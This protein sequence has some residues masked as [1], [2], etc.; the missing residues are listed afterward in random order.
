M[1]TSICDLNQGGILMTVKPVMRE[2][3]IG[4]GVSNVQYERWGTGAR[5]RG[6]SIQEYI[7]YAVDTLVDLDTN[8]LPYHKSLRESVP[9]GNP[10][11]G[12]VGEPQ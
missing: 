3:R 4:L 11:S 12:I 2:R 8:H 10:T 7:R 6:L 1:W 5:L 9:P